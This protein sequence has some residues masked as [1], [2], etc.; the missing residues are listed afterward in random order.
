MSA[1]RSWR[2]P[3]PTS[4]GGTSSAT[5]RRGTAWA[6][7]ELVG[8]LAGEGPVA[9]LMDDDHLSGDDVEAVL[10]ELS[11]R[12]SLKLVLI[13]TVLPEFADG[14]DQ[15]IQLGGLEESVALELLRSIVGSGAANARFVAQA[16]G[17]PLFLFIRK[18][19]ACSTSLEC[20]GTTTPSVSLRRSEGLS[21]PGSNACRHLRPGCLRQPHPSAGCSRW[22]RRPRSA[23]SPPRTRTDCLSPRVAEPPRLG[24][25]AATAKTPP[26]HTL[27]FARSRETV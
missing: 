27:S 18:R 3:W 11:V 16:D 17:N 4:S 2:R 8:G 6:I 14:Y 5:D 20:S 12:P 7:A 1:G 13:R 25:G 23:V 22:R 19:L 9:L 15:V 24:W 26:S 21:Q 10:H